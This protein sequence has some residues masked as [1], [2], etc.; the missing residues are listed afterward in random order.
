MPARNLPAAT[1][2][3]VSPAALLSSSP[4]T[5]SYMATLKS[6]FVA[7]SINAHR[8]VCRTHTQEPAQVSGVHGGSSAFGQE[9]IAMLDH[10][11]TTEELSWNRG[12][13]LV[14]LRPVRDAVV[15]EFCAARNKGE[16]REVCASRSIEVR[17]LGFGL[18]GWH[19]TVVNCTLVVPLSA[20]SQ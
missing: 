10:R 7:T 18:R 3:A 11:H 2:S 12:R 17:Q 8:P 19:Y 6:S 4:K 14:Y 5:H 15:L 9:Q 1:G 13:I 16:A 20:T